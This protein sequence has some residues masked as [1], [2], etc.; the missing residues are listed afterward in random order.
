MYRLCF[1]KP[2]RATSASQLAGDQGFPF[3]P[4]EIKDI[5]KPNFEIGSSSVE[6]NSWAH[7]LNLDVL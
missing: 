3:G 4:H 5:K 2:W 1:V 7:I 6:S